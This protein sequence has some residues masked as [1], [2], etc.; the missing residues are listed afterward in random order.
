MRRAETRAAGLVLGA[1]ACA[2][3]LLGPTSWTNALAGAGCLLA[4]GFGLWR[5]GWIGSTHR[6]VRARW[7]ADGRWQLSD[8]PAQPAPAADAPA[9]AQ[10]EESE[11][12]EDGLLAVL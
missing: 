11:H 2:V 9:V 8:T 3:L 6:I 10:P 12:P 1:G 5:A 4:L 7:L